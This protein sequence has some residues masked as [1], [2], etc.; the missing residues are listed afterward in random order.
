MSLLMFLLVM[1]VSNG[2]S[3]DRGST[4]SCEWKRAEG[5]NLYVLPVWLPGSL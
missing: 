5:P 3:R 1:R 4:A 2:T